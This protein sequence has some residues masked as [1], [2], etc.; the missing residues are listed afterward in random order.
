VPLSAQLVPQIAERVALALVVGGDGGERGSGE[1]GA[2]EPRDGQVGAKAGDLGGKGGY[3][4][5]GSEQMLPDVG[6]MLGCESLGEVSREPVP[7]GDLIQVG[8]RGETGSVGQGASLLR[9]G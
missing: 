7:G 2:V 8:R 6:G 4:G 9:I 3:V 5:E 1:V